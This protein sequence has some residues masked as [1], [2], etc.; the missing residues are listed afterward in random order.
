MFSSWIYDELK[1]YAEELKVAHPAKLKAIEAD[2]AMRQK[3]EER[4]GRK[5]TW[6][7]VK[8]QF[9]GDA[10]ANKY[11]DVERR[12]PWALPRTV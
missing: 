6:D 2:V 7:P 4:L 9:P 10:E 8:E 12:K 3:I 1:P 11:L 5:L